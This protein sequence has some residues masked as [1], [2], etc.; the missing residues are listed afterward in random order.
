MTAPPRCQSTA[1]DATPPTATA[2][3]QQ[4]I[5]RG[6]VAALTSIKHLGTNGGGWFNTNSAHPFENPNPITNVLENVLMALLPMGLIYT[7]GIMINRRKQASTFFWVMAGFFL[8]FLVI[9]YAGEIQGNPL[10]TS[11]GLDPVAGQPGGS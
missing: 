7:L 8:V 3:G 11:I 4:T 1:A 2:Q 6:P 5:T 10:L 9:A